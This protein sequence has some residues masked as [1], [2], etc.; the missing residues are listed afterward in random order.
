ME[1]ETQGFEA[2]APEGEPK[3]LSQAEV[4][5]IVSRE[6]YAAREQ[7][8]K[9][10]EAEY[11]A[12]IDKL[13]GINDSSLDKEEL[14]NS[15]IEELKRDN[16]AFQ[17]A[18]TREAQK[19]FLAKRA[20]SYNQKMQ[21]AQDMP[22]DFEDIISDFDLDNLAEVAFLAEEME[23]TP[24][25]MYELAKNPLK[26]AGIM[27]LANRSPKEARKA[28]KKLSDSIAKNQQ[29]QAEH[30]P[31][32]PPLSQLK[33]SKAGADTGKMTLTDFKNASW[34]KV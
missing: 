33:P 20:D 16:Q 18:Q 27:E 10:L 24:H 11:Q 2:V 34:L 8:R 7:A 12:K 31:T 4:D 3:I 14:R 1:Q 5:A 23:N 13:Q 9:Q 15:V 22:E 32:E 30:I 29:A 21:S 28:M 19:A 17:E 25:I 6:K 26:A